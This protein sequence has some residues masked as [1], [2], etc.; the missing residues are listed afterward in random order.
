MKK[1]I[2]IL[3]IISILQSIAILYLLNEADINDARYK[4]LFDR[5]QPDLIKL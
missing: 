5:I 2:I 4:I 3:I 1:T